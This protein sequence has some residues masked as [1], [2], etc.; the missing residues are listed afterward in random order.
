MSTDIIITLC[1]IFTKRYISSMLWSRE[2]NKNRCIT[3]LAVG[4]LV[5][6]LSNF[7]QK[8]KRVNIEII[9]IILSNKHS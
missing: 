3:T 1:Y 6:V 2:V 7:M 9:V 5:H 8:R 4:F